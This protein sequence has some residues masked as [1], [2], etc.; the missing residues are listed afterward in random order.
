MSQAFGVK[1]DVYGRF[2]IEV[3]REGDAWVAYR[4]EPG[5][6]IRIPEL[7]IPSILEASEIALF[8][9]DL[10]HEMSRPGQAIRAL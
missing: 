7:G 9:D 4:L 10:Y 5:K 3:A 1:F 6:R 8:L 2:H